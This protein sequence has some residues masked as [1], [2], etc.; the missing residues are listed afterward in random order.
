MILEGA[1]LA[2]EMYERFA[3][4][5]SYAETLD[6]ASLAHRGPVERV[7]DWLCALLLR[8]V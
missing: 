1:G 4:K 3:R 5:L 7:V 6:V 8:F 2:N